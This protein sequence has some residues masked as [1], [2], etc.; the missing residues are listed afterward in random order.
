MKMLRKNWW[1]I[2]MII[3]LM[4]PAGMSAKRKKNKHK[5][6]TTE[7]AM[8]Q[9]QS[10]L[11]A[12][13]SLTAVRVNPR[14]R[15]SVKQYTA[16]TVNFNPS[17]RVP[18]C[19]SYMLTASMVAVTDGPNAQHRRNYKFYADPSVSGC[20][21]WWEYKRSGYD[22]GHMA[23]AN[24]MRWSRQSMSDCFLMTNIC[25]QDHDMNGGSWNKL[26]LKVH[27]WARLHGKI[28]VVTGPIF[29]GSGKRIGNNNDIVVPAGFFKVVLDP[30]RNRAIG[31]LYNNREEPGG[32]KRHAC[33]VD[34]VERVTGHDFFSSLPDNVERQVEGTFNFEQWQ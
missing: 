23:P 19:V 22:R 34:E 33:S 24:D 9:R 17:Y 2:A 21:E 14:Y 16:M 4:V 15:N 8:T 6:F 11:V 26:E 13:S 25:P 5:V 31:F 28:V 3:V 20:P 30:A 1:V 32:V 12:N 27:D 7:Q 18:N 10:Q 29:N